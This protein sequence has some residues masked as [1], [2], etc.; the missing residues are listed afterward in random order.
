MDGLDLLDEMRA[1]R[2]RAAVA[3]VSV[4]AFLL[5]V[6]FVCAALVLGAR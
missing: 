4:G 3:A 1:S 5:A 6:M 2:K